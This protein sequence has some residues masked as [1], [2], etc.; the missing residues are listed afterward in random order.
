MLIHR[1][2]AINVSDKT[3]LRVVGLKLIEPPAGYRPIVHVWSGTSQ[4]GHF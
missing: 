1:K 3:W 4:C 2:L